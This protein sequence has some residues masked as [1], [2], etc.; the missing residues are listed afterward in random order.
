MKI[1][2]FAVMAVAFFAT[3]SMCLLY[4]VNPPLNLTTKFF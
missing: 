4:A 2:N 1:V 3:N